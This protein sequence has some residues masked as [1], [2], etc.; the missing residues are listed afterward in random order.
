MVKYICNGCLYETTRKS[1]IE[2]HVNRMN[3][4]SEFESDEK[5]T[6][7]DEKQ[8]ERYSEIFKIYEE[9]KCK[10]LT[11]LNEY[12]E[13]IN[14]NKNT[15]DIKVH[16]LATCGH[17]NVTTTRYFV[18]Q[19]YINCKNCAI[20][21]KYKLNFENKNCK[22]ITT[23]D[24][25]NLKR[26][27]SSD[28]EDITVN[29]IAKCNHENDIR[30]SSFSIGC[31]LICKKCMY[32]NESNCISIL[33]GISD[34]KFKKSRPKFLNGL[35]LDG[36]NSELKLAIEY[37]GIQHYKYIPYFHKNG[38][39]DLEKQQ[40][41]DYIKNELCIKNDIYLIIVPFWIKDIKSF[42]TEQYII[43]DFLRSYTLT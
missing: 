12:L 30:L 35:E 41:R 20:Y 38:K 8:I 29:Y 15:R 40:K 4:C 33:E 9:N 27:N 24:E 11:S 17:E 18:D 3:K 19:N 10:L 21:Q 23:L 1:T 36:Y 43:F 5:Y 6:R 13:L 32:K 28:I 37:N 31:G 34:F 39:V 14:I 16:Y 26:N 2:N 25:F 7:F 42:L 22:L